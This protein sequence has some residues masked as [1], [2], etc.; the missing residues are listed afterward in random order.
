MILDQN[1]FR[2]MPNAFNAPSASPSTLLNIKSPSSSSL[3]VSKTNKPTYLFHSCTV[4]LNKIS[5][6]AKSE[7]KKR[8]YAIYDTE[9]S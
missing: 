5:E 7:K 4:H 9:S 8:K 6:N 3:V 1:E 2:E